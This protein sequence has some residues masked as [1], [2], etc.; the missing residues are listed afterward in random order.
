[1][2]CYPNCPLPI[3]TA[4]YV[5]SPETAWWSFIRRDLFIK[6]GPWSERETRKLLLLQFFSPQGR[7]ATVRFSRC[8]SRSWLWSDKPRLACVLAAEDDI[9]VCASALAEGTFISKQCVKYMRRHRGLYILIFFIFFP[10][11]YCVCRQHSHSFLQM[12]FWGLA[13]LTPA[14]GWVVWM[15]V[16]LRNRVCAWSW[17]W[18]RTAALLRFG[19]K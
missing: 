16:L 12:C 19:R 5:K 11:L 1:M 10:P 15:L 7:L 3:V 2:P 18:S 4:W 8:V 6:L 14:L 9:H 17:W 13:F